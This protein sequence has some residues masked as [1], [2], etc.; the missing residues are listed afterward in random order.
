MSAPTG[1]H[2]LEA[3]LRGY[4]REPFGDGGLS[5][6]GVMQP[7]PA[8]FESEKMLDYDARTDNQPVYVGFAESSIKTGAP[9]ASAGAWII[10]KFTYD[11]SD[12]VTRIQ[13]GRGTWDGRAA[14]F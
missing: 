4:Y 12:R 8:A 13:V 5:A 9:S 7:L 2:S 14:L 6:F 1:P 3:M 10:Q 11:G